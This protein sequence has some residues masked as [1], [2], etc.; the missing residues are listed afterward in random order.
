MKMA[1]RADRKPLRT[2]AILIA[3]TLCGVML[4]SAADATPVRT[5][6]K[7]LATD[8]RD[9]GGKLD[10]RGARSVVSS[11]DCRVTISTW[12]T[13][14]T[15][16]LHGGNYAPGRNRLAVV[17]DLNGDG[18]ADVTGYII[19]EAGGFIYLFLRTSTDTFSPAAAWRPTA[20]SVRVSLC[21]FLYEAEPPLPK[22][23]RA[24]FVSENGAHWDRMPNRGWVRLHNPLT[25]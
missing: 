16:L 15:T 6:S 9:A 23:V 12:G 25:G 19:S 4:V 17:Y 18:K 1:G 3:L 21:R 22:T 20:S 24:A 11:R 13:W 2:R 10:L 8:P 14:N 7:T 5:R